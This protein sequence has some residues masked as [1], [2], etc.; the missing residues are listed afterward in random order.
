M[1]ERFEAF[2]KNV[3]SADKFVKKIKKNEMRRFGIHGSCVMCLFYLGRSEEG[4]T[5]AEL[6]ELCDEDKAAISRALATL[7]EKNY[8]VVVDEG[9]IYRAKYCITEE[10]RAVSESIRKAVERAVFGAGNDITEEELEIFRATFGKI[11]N[12]LRTIC[13]KM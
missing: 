7:R 12:N 5:P 4:L 13:E 8:A 6:R 3:A 2:T 9:K 10:G 1:L 11:V